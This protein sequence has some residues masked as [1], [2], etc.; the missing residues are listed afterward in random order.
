MARKTLSLF[1]CIGFICALCAPLQ[2]AFA[3]T[4]SVSFDNTSYVGTHKSL[5]YFYVVEN[6]TA[7]LTDCVATIHGDLVLPE[8]LGGYPLASVGDRAFADCEG[9]SSVTVHDEKL[10]FGANVFSGCAPEL[11]LYAAKDSSAASY[12]AENNLQAEPLLI[13]GD[14]DNDGRLNLGDLTLFASYIAG[15]ENV[16]L[17]TKGADIEQDLC[18]NLHDLTK[19]SKKIAGF[20]EPPRIFI[21]GDSTACEY[22]DHLNYRTIGG[23]GEYLP[24]YLDGTYEVVN[25]ASSGASTKDY[26]TREPYL[27]LRNELGKGDY[28]FIGLGINDNKANDPTR[29]SDPTADKDTPGSF[30][31][32]LYHNYVSLAYEVGAT[33]IFVTSVCR[34]PSDGVTFSNADLHITKDSNGKNGGDY[35]AAMKAL[36]AELNIPVLDMTTLSKNL[37][38]SL[39]AEENALLHKWETDDPATLDRTHYSVYGA[40]YM[41]FLLSGLIR[42]QI[43][44]L[45]P[46]VNATAQA[47][48]AQEVDTPCVRTQTPSLFYY[49]D[50]SFSESYDATIS[51]TSYSVPENE[52]L[53]QAILADGVRAI[54]EKAFE[55]QSELETVRL[56]Q[57]LL[58]IGIGAFYK[59]SN[60][61]LSEFP[62]NLETIHYNSFYGCSSIT[63]DEIPSSVLEIG[64]S[65]FYNCTSLTSLKIDAA[66]TFFGS[67]TFRGCT[68]LETVSLPIFLEELPKNAFH[69]CSALRE[70]QMHDNLTLI[71]ENAVRATALSSFVIP[72]AVRQI[73]NYAFYG[74]KSL[75]TLHY[76]GSCADFYRITRADKW[77]YGSKF[78]SIVCSDGTL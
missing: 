64:A 60:L 47:P 29:Y 45:A 54:Y 13:L 36:G 66:V 73:D 6:E 48:T 16:S 22:S 25:L 67:N 8:T 7:I 34:R 46:Y 40:N 14:C 43:P 75:K 42:E 33:P 50:G 71:G 62:T 39:G 59:C 74:T 57:S 32:Y 17:H 76:E 2:T 41:A 51:A 72:K 55:N 78:T 30:Q 3:E 11:V 56:P 15:W 19:L 53:T 18:L 52:F 37:H 61:K 35:P 58:A 77:S 65:A 9:L 68:A 38:L 69:T 44:E 28:L 1:L 70:L 23:Y 4:Q 20:S 21:V 49:S 12:A 31:Y 24:Q 10:T 27:Q 5:P 26:V 63:V